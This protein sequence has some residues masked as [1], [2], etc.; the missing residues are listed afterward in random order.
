MGWE[1]RNPVSSPRHQINLLDEIDGNGKL[2]HKISS[3]Y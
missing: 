2:G 1:R 3:H